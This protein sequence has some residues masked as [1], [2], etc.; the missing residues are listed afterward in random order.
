MGFTP[1]PGSHNEHNEPSDTSA[2][3][4]ANFIVFCLVAYGIIMGLSQCS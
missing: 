2:Q 3:A 1:P 4:I